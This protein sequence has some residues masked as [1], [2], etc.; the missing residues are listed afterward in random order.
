[1]TINLNFAKLIETCCNIGSNNYI[2]YISN[3]I[4]T[5]PYRIYTGPYR[6]YTGPYRIYT[7]PYRIYTG[8]YRIYR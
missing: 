2:T 4:Y 8:P 5:G 3:R 6:I 7:G 1:L